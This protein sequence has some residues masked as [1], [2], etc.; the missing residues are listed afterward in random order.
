M[1]ITSS[2]V[3][4]AVLIAAGSAAFLMPWTG[5]SSPAAVPAGSPSAVAD[6]ARP[7]LTISTASGQFPDAAF[8]CDF[9]RLYPNASW[10]AFANN[11]SH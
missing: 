8:I 11:F 10:E 6:C 7:P 5:G 4:G 3:A 1:A 2:I 9:G